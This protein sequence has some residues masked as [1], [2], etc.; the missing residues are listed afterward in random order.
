MKIPYLG[1]RAFT[2]VTDKDILVYLEKYKGYLVPVPDEANECKD[3]SAREAYEK[4]SLGPRL[5]ILGDIVEGFRGHGAHISLIKQ[6]GDNNRP[7]FVVFYESFTGDSNGGMCILDKTL[8][9]R[10]C[11]LYDEVV[12]KE[13]LAVTNNLLVLDATKMPSVFRLALEKAYGIRK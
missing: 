11:K 8:Y 6:K 7:E 12:K 2:D 1:N 4:A 5:I 13:E 10:F 3:K 9:K